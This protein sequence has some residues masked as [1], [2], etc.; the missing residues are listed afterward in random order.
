[1]KVYIFGNEDLN[2]DNRAFKVAEKL[3]ADF[4]NVEF[5][6][7]KPNEDLPF[8]EEKHL[9]IMDAVQG[10][11]NVEELSG[12]DLD[13]LALSPRASVHDF[14]LG[15]QLKYLKKLGKL[16]EVIIIGLPMQGEIDYFLIHSIFKKLVAQD[17]QGS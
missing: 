16:G 3:T 15:F 1:M 7:V 6:K 12:Q 5:I 13:R 10:I 14:D 9:I 2:D 8:A 17:M 4:D 11:E